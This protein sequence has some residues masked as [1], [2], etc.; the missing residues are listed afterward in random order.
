M[1]GPLKAYQPIRTRVVE[2][3]EET[4]FFNEY[5]RRYH[6]LGEVKPFGC[7]LRY[8]VINRGH[9][10]GLALFAGAAKALGARDRWIGWTDKQRLQNLGWVINNTRL[11]FFPWVRVKN[12]ASHVLAQIHRQV[13]DD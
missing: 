13:R 1:N 10:L 9:R 7:F 6:Y 2:G 8:F 4:L 5:L 3:K 12:L 11:L